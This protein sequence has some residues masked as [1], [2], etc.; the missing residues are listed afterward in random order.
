MPA[1]FDSNL[2]RRLSELE[3]EA[4]DLRRRLE[5]QTV[6]GNGLP[7][8]PTTA[9]MDHGIASLTPVL[10]NSSTSPPTHVVTMASPPAE[11][12]ELPTSPS[13]VGT[14]ARSLDGVLVQATTI[15][16]LFSL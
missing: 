16:E 14:Q 3:K 8:T 6:W 11:T 7:P 2:R 10:S 12:F 13:P 9:S 5:T 1:Q 15:D 4:L